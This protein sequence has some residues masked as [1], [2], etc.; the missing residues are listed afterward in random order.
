MQTPPLGLILPQDM[1]QQQR[2]AH[3]KAL[4]FRPRFAMLGGVPAGPVKIML[5]DMWKDPD[6]AKDIGM[7]FPGFHQITGSCVGASSGN[8][9]FTLGAVQRKLSDSPTVAFIPFWPYQYG[10]TRQAEGDRGQGEGA[11][12][13][14]MGQ[15]VQ[16][17][18]LQVTG[19][20]GLPQFDTSDGLA[21]TK[22]QELQWSMVNSGFA[23]Y[24]PIAAKNPVGTVATLTSTADIYQAIVNG[25]PVIDGCSMYIGHGKV[26][27][28][29]DGACVLGTYDGRGGH[30]TCLLG[31]WDHPTLGRLFLYSNQ[32]PAETYPADPAGGGRCC[33]WVKEADVQKHLFSSDNQGQVM[34][35][36]HLTYFPAQP[37][38]LDWSMA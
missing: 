3:E 14:V 1:N 33:V 12:D 5:T 24:D 29:G 22:Q 13:S 21:L 35:A 6:V 37:Q 7:A 32:W 27:G 19:Q 30:S 10:R 36:S 18:V 11:V 8:W 34:A 16:K 2:D 4:A 38:V 17:G 26:Q 28:S 20:T 9:I 31:A 15:T 25:Y 23:Q